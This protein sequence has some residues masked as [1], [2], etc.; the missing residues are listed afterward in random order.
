MEPNPGMDSSV[1]EF[2]ASAFVVR[3]DDV[4]LIGIAVLTIQQLQLRHIRQ[5]CAQSNLRRLRGS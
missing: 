5:R 4:E 3:V 1:P 2:S